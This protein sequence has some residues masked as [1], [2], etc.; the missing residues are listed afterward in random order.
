MKVRLNYSI[1]FFWCFASLAHAGGKYAGASM[2]LGLGARALALGGSAAALTGSADAFF[3]NPSSLAFIKHPILSLMY[4]PCFGS[5]TS[6]L[7]TYHYAGMTF[8]LP[9]GGTLAVSWTRFAVDEIPVYPELQGSSFAERLNDTNLRPDGATLGYFNDVEDVYYF[10]FARPMN[11]LL[12]LGWLFTDLPVE[13]PLGLNLKLLR[14]RLYQS[15]ASGLGVDVG[16]MI[17][18]DLG[19]LLDQ[20][21]IGELT[22][23]LSALDITQTTIVWDTRHEDRVHRTLQLGVAYQHDV[24]LLGAKWNLYWT[25]QKKYESVDLFGTEFVVKGLS[26]RLGKNRTGLTAGTGLQLWRLSIDYAFVSLD[27]NNS[28]RLNCSISL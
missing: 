25:Q 7:A 24:G 5:I 8:P 17:H 28:H 15:K 3:Y 13:M 10:S 6:P 12:P 18:F 11:F 19:R 16:T 2:E 20:R 27:L 21:A 1:V 9:N 4:A 14:Q 26:I 23:G 22:V